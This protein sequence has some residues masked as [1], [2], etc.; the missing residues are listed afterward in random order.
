MHQTKQQGTYGASKCK[1]T[2]RIDIPTAMERP[3]RYPLSPPVVSHDDWC[4][5]SKIDE[6]SGSRISSS[7]YSETSLDVLWFAP[8]K[9]IGNNRAN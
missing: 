1:Y 8:E 2:E 6:I 3:V 5:V 7:G 9:P 4:H